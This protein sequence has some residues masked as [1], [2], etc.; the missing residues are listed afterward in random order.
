MLK[1]DTHLLQFLCYDFWRRIFEH[2]FYL[3]KIIF[4]YY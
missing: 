3:I 4:E 1:L 2:A